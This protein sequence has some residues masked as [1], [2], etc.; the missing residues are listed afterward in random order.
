MKGQ[1]NNV[2]KQN[3]SLYGFKQ[4]PK[5]RNE[6]LDQLLLC[7]DFTFVEV[8]KCAYTKFVDGHSVMWMTCLFLVLF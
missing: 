3:K 5:Q 4:A 1:E 2:C 8:D 7:N 6:K